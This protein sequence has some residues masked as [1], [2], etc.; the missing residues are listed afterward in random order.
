MLLRPISISPDNTPGRNVDGGGESR[1]V[2]SDKNR[3]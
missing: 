1:E 3:L 2:L